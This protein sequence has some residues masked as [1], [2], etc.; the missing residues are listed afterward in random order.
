MNK[1]GGSRFS[2]GLVLLAVVA[3]L[4]SGQGIGGAEPSAW[5]YTMVAFSNTNDRD[6]DVYESGDGTQFA[7]VQLGA[8]RPQAGLVRD[9]SIFRHTDG[10]YYLTYTTGSGATIGFARSVDRVSWTPM[11]N[12]PVPFCCAFLPGTGDG[13]GSA[14]L[15]G[16]T[17]SAGSSDGPSL[18][19]FTTKA[20]APE[21]FVD[22]SSVNV[23]VSLS[24][25]GGF[26]PYLMTA[27]NPSLTAWSFPVPLAGIGADHIDTTVVE[28]GN[29]YHAF[30]KN[31]TTKVV[32][33]AVSPSLAGPY[34]FVPPG[35]WGSFVEGP[36]VV[37][38]PNGAWRIYLDKY[39]E[40]RYLY[41]DSSDG[42]RTWSPVNELPGLSG[43]VR[44]VGVLREPA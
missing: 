1:T 34:T 7:P 8:F 6:M 29:T 13:T 21:W 37:Q 4:V 43:T 27:L 35:N 17:G 23:I 11:G 12:Y 15:P 40:N 22:G 16:F 39:T 9:P 36:A 26:V 41:S 38:L 42:M 25:G 33:H 14:S 20:W 10:S 3:L 31:E 24:T 5:R 19:P 28:V 18:S 32:E 2:I 30:T 44:H